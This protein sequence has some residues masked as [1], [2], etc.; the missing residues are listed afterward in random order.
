MQFKAHRNPAP[1]GRRLLNQTFRIMKITAFLLILACLQVSAKRGTAQTV[2]LALKNATLEKVFSE[3]ERQTGYYFVYTREILRGAR[4]ID[5][6][7]TNGDLTRV[8][9]ECLKERPLAYSIVNKMIVL[10]RRSIPVF[11]A[12]DSSQLPSPPADIRGHVTDSLGNPLAGASISVKGTKKGAQTDANGNF[13]MTGIDDH[14]VLVVSFTGYRPV[15]IKVF[16]KKSVLIALRPGSSELDQIQVI[17][18][19]TISKR[20]N[21]G[22]VTTITAETIAEQPVSNPLA[23][24]EGRVPG[25]IVTQSSGVPGGSFNVQ[26]RGRTALDLSITDDQPLFIIDGVPFAPNNNFTNQLGSALGTP[27]TALGVTH[28]GGTSPFNSINPQDIESI[29]VLKDADA[30]AI[31]GSRGAN[32]V[33]LITT[34]KGHAGKTTF[35]LNIY[36]GTSRVTRTMKMLDTKQY[37]DVRRQAFANDSVAPDVDN[38]FD[39]LSYDTT[40]YTDFT[41]LLIGGTAH[42]T[43]AQASISGGN[44]N[45]QFILGSSYHHESTVFPGNLG[46]NRATMHFNLSHASEDQRL[47]IVFSSIYSTDKNNLIMSDLASYVT[48]PPN[49]Q[50]FDSTGKLAWTEGGTVYYENPLAYLNERYT[51]QTD[52]LLSNMVLSYKV[53]PQLTFR[54]SGGY[55]DVS[56]NESTDYPS[57]AQNPAYQAY[58]YSEFA[59]NIFKSWILEPQAEYNAVIGKGKL[60]ILTGGTWQDQWNNGSDVEGD[61]YATDALLGDL[62]G[63]SSVEGSQ[64]YSDYKYNAVFGRVN[65]NLQNKYLL[66]LSGRRDGSSRFGPGNQYANFG[67]LGAAWIF[68]EEPWLKNKSDVLSFGKL[69]SSYGTTGNDKISN[70]QYLDTWSLSNTTLTYEDSSGYYPNKL[71]NPNYRWERT[72]KF[73]LALELGFLK[74]RILFSMDYYR[75]RSSN[76]LVQYQL[77][78]STGFTGVIENFPALVQ[79]TG[80]ELTLNAINIKSRNF[81]WVTTINLTIPRNK[82]ISFPG[83]SNSSYS[84]LYVQGQ[85]LNVIYGFQFLGVDPATGYYALK[86]V[87]QDGKLT[88]KNDYVAS[89]NRDPAYYGGILNTVHFHHLQLDVFFEFRRQTGRNFL[90]NLGTVPGS[91][92]NIPAVMLDNWKKPGD[93][94]P[95]RKFSQGDPSLPYNLIGD[96]T[97]TTNS[98]VYGDASFIRLKNLA[99][100]YNLSPAWLTKNHLKGARIYLQG[101]NLLT[102]TR[103]LG[104]DPETQDFQRLPP[105]QTLTAGLQ[106]TF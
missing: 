20:L 69:R 87:N 79:N 86:D 104:S 36:T 37:L 97:Y 22:S 4:N 55:N 49:L 24:L 75:N 95:Y 16:G 94:K 78:Y 46:D 96:P 93:I 6:S 12:G 57:T 43:D 54:I 98:G 58:R 32:G 88:S 62:A 72:R 18:Y 30:T 33:I 59:T 65:Y 42:T 92:G 5:I 50:L 44:A 64:T 76:Q 106:F 84:G 41:K 52:N 91:L 9:D 10:N 11:Q 83:L 74:D 38:A 7:V 8:L 68:S 89:G 103:Y 53:L 40:R 81:T 102:I 17:A 90:N 3:I 34:K 60:N 35:D 82:L 2:T 77:P 47:K 23:A 14:A 1:P 61:G 27:S 66:N 39:L 100:S 21:T 28:P 26:V 67:S 73:E 15:E 99:I 48:L 51:A 80:L 101:Q 45:T 85:S 19:G 105:L 25:M 31:Y 29:E 56:L 71:Y 13:S 63:A 70:Y